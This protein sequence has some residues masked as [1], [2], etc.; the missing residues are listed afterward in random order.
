MGYKLD[1]ASITDKGGREI[2][3]DAF[4]T[5]IH[6]SM[7]GFFLCDGLGG[8]GMGDVASALAIQVFKKSFES[9][10]D[11]ASFFNMAFNAAQDILL[12]EQNARKAQRKMKTTAVTVLT[13]DKYAYIAHVG[14]SRAYVFSRNK[15]KLHT[16][17]H[18]IPQMLVKSGEIKESEIRNHPDRNTLLRVL[19]IEW[20]EPQYEVMKPIPLRKCQAFLL[21][22][23]GFW[24]L[25][26]EEQMEACLIQASNVQEWLDAMT[27]I[28]RQ[29]GVGRN[30]DNY[31]AVAIWNLGKKG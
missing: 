18:S 4:G 16:L 23:D 28:V 3:E 27:A 12:A 17:D 30:M 19:G 22:S 9:T 6:N 2:N 24:E 5:A 13:D 14:D 7:Y 26:T 10:S 21:C 29:N 31:T 20:H 15:A 8:H 25:I 1:Y 11:V